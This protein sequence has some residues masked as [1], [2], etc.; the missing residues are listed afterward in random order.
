MRCRAR[1]DSDSGSE[2]CERKSGHKGWHRYSFTAAKI[3][4]RCLWITRRQHAE[5]VKEQK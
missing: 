2:V 4:Y 3:K 1:T 5:H